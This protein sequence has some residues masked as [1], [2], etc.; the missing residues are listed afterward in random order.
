MANVNA[1]ALKKVEVD[2]VK[3]E[4]FKTGSLTV[5]SLESSKG[6]KAW[7]ASR[8]SPFDRWNNV[9]GDEIAFGRALKA[10]KKKTLGKEVFDKYAG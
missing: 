3:N 4:L 10:L 1:S 7:G 5:I 2:V 9:K 8:K 6:I